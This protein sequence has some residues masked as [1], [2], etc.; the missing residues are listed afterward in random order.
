MSS[1][2][3]DW[4]CRGQKQVFRP[5]PPRVEATAGDLRQLHAVC[6]KTRICVMAADS[7]DTAAEPK[8]VKLTL[9]RAYLRGR[10]TTRVAGRNWP[11]K[12]VVPL[13]MA[14]RG[15][16]TS[17][18]RPLGNV[19]PNIQSSQRQD[20]TLGMNEARSTWNSRAIIPNARA[21]HTYG[22]VSCSA[23][24]SFFPLRFTISE[25]CE[26]QSIPIASFG[27][28]FPSQTRS[29]DRLDCSVITGEPSCRMSRNP[30]ERTWPGRPGSTQVHGPCCTVEPRGVGPD[31]LAS[32]R[33][34]S[35][36]GAS[37]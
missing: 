21:A 14:E 35:P 1:A 5:G 34:G 15:K 30:I 12:P 27:S 23:S 17:T 7:A 10:S 32:P 22:A 31:V 16:L 11:P 28:F 4:R 13:Y 25:S 18:P 29:S 6:L 36:V 24:P 8:L 33:H 19:R 37:M 3:T 2:A 9:V 20:L 26:A